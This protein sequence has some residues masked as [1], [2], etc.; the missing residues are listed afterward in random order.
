MKSV[1]TG[2][3]EENFDLVVLGSGPGGQRAAVQ[4]A[5]A[6]KRVA[7]I[8]K[9]HKMGGGCVHWGTLPSKSLRES[10]YRWSLGSKGILGR[11]DQNGFVVDVETADLPDMSR[12]MRRK[13]RVIE[14]ES[15]I[16]E[17]QL[18]RNK[19]AT[20]IGEGSFIGEKLLRVK[21]SDGTTSTISTEVAIIAVGA[22]PVTPAKFRPDGV[23][24]LDSDTILH[25]QKTPKSMVVL[26]AGII[27][28]EYASIFQAAGVHVTL[29]LKVLKWLAKV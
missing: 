25:L 12:L 19:V 18:V 28:C 24:V 11:M 27:G 8:E 2:V 5:K 4:A 16:V 10:V 15:S 26:G 22:S 13:E 6:G 20:Y 14:T 29:K 9:Y 3:P 7:L 17:E 21:H 23:R 1:T